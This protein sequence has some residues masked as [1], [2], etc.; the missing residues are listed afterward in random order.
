M[1]VKDLIA[2]FQYAL[3][4]HWGYI[5]GTAGELWTES[6]QHKATR[7]QTIE[8]GAQ[9]IGH[10]VADC[11]GLFT[12]AFAELGGYMYHGSNTMYKSYCTAKGALQ[13]G[14]RSDGKPL[15]P[16]T[17]FFTGTE[18]NRGH[19][20]LYIGEGEVIEAAG[21]KQGV[22]LSKADSAKWA[23]WGE[24]KGVSYT[25]ADD[26][27][28]PDVLGCGPAVVDVPNNGTVNVREKPSRDAKKIDTIRE[29]GEVN[30]LAVSGNWASVEY[31]RRGFIQADYLK[32]K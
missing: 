6:K 22:I 24:L 16:G 30:V 1:K 19:V 28:V 14:H 4:N 9:W 20:G 10:R 5:W 11:S 26:A 13:G 18:A 17:A 7:Q 21:T 12:W 31:T 29:G 2:K 27:P 3:E 23:W 8:Y 32:K 25:D 15:K